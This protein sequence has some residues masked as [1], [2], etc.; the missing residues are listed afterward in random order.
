MA[1]GIR[2]IPCLLVRGRGLW[3]TT[4]FRDPVYVGDPVNVARIFNDKRAH[5]LVILDIGA[6][7]GNPAPRD[8]IAEIASE[9]FM[10]SC[11]G[12][13]IRSLDQIQKLLGMGVEKVAINTHAIEDPAF[14]EEAA[15]TFGSSTITVSID[16]R[17][18]TDGTQHVYSHGGMRATGRT[19]VD[20][21]REMEAR[22]A[23]ELLLTSIDREGTR[24]GYDLDLVRSVAAAVNIPVVAHGGAGG[25]GDMRDAVQ[26][27]ASAAAAGNLFSFYG[28]LR[29]VLITYPPRAEL[30]SLTA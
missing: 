7:Q 22:G 27:G 29:G 15:V 30:S 16:V 2:V 5:E 13:G 9:C 25:V 14:V 10:P 1:R 8:L 4:R 18:Q 26:A 17:R 28:R 21:A 20:H 23:G 12:G 6:T 24:T 3:K 11:I 19:A